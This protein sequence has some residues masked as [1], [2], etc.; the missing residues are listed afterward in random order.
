MLCNR[1]LYTAVLPDNTDKTVYDRHIF[2][3]EDNQ[4]ISLEAD[5]FSAL[6]KSSRV[7]SEPNRKG[8]T[9][10]SAWG[11]CCKCENSGAIISWPKCRS[12]LYKSYQWCEYS[13]ESTTFGG[14]EGGER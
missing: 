9:E 4:S 3:E 2:A 10:K 1:T 11:Q 13:E 5:Q 8:E 6:P 7:Y 14:E 12:C